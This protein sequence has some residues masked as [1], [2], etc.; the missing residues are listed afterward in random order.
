MNTNKTNILYFDLETAPILG[1]AWQT[2]DT[3]LL[4][5]E[6]DSHLLAFAYKLNNEPIHVFS[7]REYTERQMVKMLWDLFNKADII[8]AQN[9]DKFD[10]RWANRLFI[11]YKLKPP[12]PYKTVDTLKI[13]RKYFKFT[14]NK[15]DFLAHMLLGEGKIE[16]GL[17]LW[18]D[19]VRGDVKALKQM[20]TYCAHDVNLLVRVYEILRAW[21]TGH[22]NLNITNCTTH[23]CPNCG[24]NTQKRGHMVTR[25]GKYQRYA[26][27]SCGAWSRG[28]RIKIDKPIS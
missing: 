7:R 22:P 1:F 20:E 13:A 8:V 4:H 16:T 2:Y 5:V 25:V 21:H 24:G 28:E 15:L 6:K 12:S 18:L 26:C 14:S 10:I 3:S 27:T 17:S 23:K 9:G 19:C 11:K